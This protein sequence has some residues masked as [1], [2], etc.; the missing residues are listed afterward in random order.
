MSINLSLLFIF[1]LNVIACSDS[2]TPSNND[3]TVQSDSGIQSDSEIIADLGPCGNVVCET[4]P[5]DECV[6]DE[7]HQY[8]SSGS[9]DPSDG[10]C[11]YTYTITPCPNGCSNGICNPPFDSKINYLK[12]HNAGANDHFGGAI[13]ISGDTL[14]VGAYMESGSATTINGPD[15]DLAQESGAVY[16]YTKETTGWVQQAYL[17]AHNARANHRFGRSVAIDGDTIVVGAPGEDSLD[18]PTEG[19]STDTGAVYVFTRSGKTWTEQAYLKASNADAKDEF[20]ASVAI[21]GDT[22]AVGATGEASTA[23]GL[24]GDQ[25]SN[26]A[27]YSGAVYL[28]SRTNSKWEQIHYIKAYN[29]LY[30]YQF[31][32]AVAL[33][34]DMLVVG[35]KTDS[36]Y[37]TG[38]VTGLETNELAPESGA[39]YVYRKT[40]NKWEYEAYLKATN[41]DDSDNFG[42]S[43]AISGSRIAIGAIKEDSS[44]T[45][46]NGDLVN[47]DKLNSGAVYILNRVNDVWTYEAYLKASNTGAE[48]YFGYN[49]AFDGDLL[50]V[51]AITESS[52]AL[53]ID[54]D[55]SNDNLNKSGAIYLYKYNGTSWAFD[56]Y[57]KAPQSDIE[58][59]W[60][61]SIALSGDTLFYSS[62][63]E[64]SSAQG[65][66]GNYADNSVL[67]SG[68][69]YVQILQ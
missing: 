68:A 35:S 55:G 49:L 23:Y 5:A 27:E 63:N 17:K 44:A 15:D 19:G 46:V 37:A 58:D 12:A 34:E 51:S 25:N 9:C 42:Y 29:S 7:A 28:F 39:I 8:A 6:N 3:S 18:K 11:S 38:D 62:T 59:R 32:N 16:V 47:N 10:S 45:G 57:I 13:A 22:I 26:N 61:R 66:N 1:L 36:Y 48:D 31:G 50:A 64:D 41:T 40:D 69:V 56:K 21:K 4:P 20:G 52:D 60:G 43:L 53:G 24:D 30:W 65:I 54:G 2:S 33:S 67:E 14:V